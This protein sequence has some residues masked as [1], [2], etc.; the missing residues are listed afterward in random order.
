MHV[1][2]WDFTRRCTNMYTCMIFFFSYT[3]LFHLRP[4]R[5]TLGCEGAAEDCRRGGSVY[6]F[7]RFEIWAPRENWAF[8][9]STSCLS[10]N[11]H[12]HT[13][14]FAGKRHISRLANYARAIFLFE[15]TAAVFFTRPCVFQ[16]QK[17]RFA[18]AAV[19]DCAGFFFVLFLP[20]PRHTLPPTPRPL[21]RPHTMSEKIWANH[22]GLWIML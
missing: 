3:Y 18:A 13:G 10:P 19:D 21:T 20:H 11:T 1:C 12:T 22:S 9:P 6:I 16:Q 15:I 4:V 7:P 2:A 17:S 8:R 14:I 5:P